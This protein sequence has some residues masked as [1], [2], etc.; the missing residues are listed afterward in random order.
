MGSLAFKQN[1]CIISTFGFSFDEETG[2]NLTRDAIFRVAE[3]SIF[4]TYVY[5]LVVEYRYR[6]SERLGE[7]LFLSTIYVRKNFY[8]RRCKIELNG[9]RETKTRH[10]RNR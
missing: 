5:M 6:A 7:R 1:P 9:R 10:W 2:I 4:I 8:M 3:E